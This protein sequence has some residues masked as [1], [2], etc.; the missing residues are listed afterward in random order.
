MKDY[1]G[2]EI[3][4]EIESQQDANYTTDVSEEKN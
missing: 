3:L 1:L 4:G 2:E